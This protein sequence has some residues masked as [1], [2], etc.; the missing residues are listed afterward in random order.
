MPSKQAI[1]S[2]LTIISHL[3]TPMVYQETVSTG[4]SRLKTLLM[5]SHLYA[6]YR[7]SMKTE[8]SVG[9]LLILVVSSQ[10]E[11]CAAHAAGHVTDFLSGAA[12]IDKRIAG[13]IMFLPTIDGAYDPKLV[14]RPTM[15]IG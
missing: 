5:Q 14:G 6:L 1:T 4:A 9:G 12:A 7:K 15:G 11:H 8:S 13:I 3:G 2:W 10:C